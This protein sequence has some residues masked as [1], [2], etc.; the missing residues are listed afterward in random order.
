MSTMPGVP[1]TPALSGVADAALTA[2]PSRQATRT[3]HVQTG[4]ASLRL[5]SRIMSHS[6]RF[7]VRF[8][9]E[10]GNP[11]GSGT[12]R[13]RNAARVNR[14]AAR[15]IRAPDVQPAG[16]A[17]SDADGALPGRVDLR[18]EAAVEV[19][20]PVGFCIVDLLEHGMGLD[21]GRCL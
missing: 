1:G 15:G 21:P 13:R 2:R 5:G 14:V 16:R 4:T 11:R 12:G 7:G 6:A 20:T 19:G 8:L 18:I 3:A 9:A 17:R 10:S